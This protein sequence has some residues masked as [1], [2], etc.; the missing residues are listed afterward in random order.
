MLCAQ[1]WSLNTNNS[2]N[3]NFD[4]MNADM[5]YKTLLHVCCIL[6]IQLITF[7]GFYIIFNKIYDIVPENITEK[8]IV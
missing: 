5:F 3:T 4:T 8:S 7:I 6:E 2:R 1:Y